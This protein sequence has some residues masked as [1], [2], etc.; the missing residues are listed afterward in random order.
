MR[1]IKASTVLL[2]L[3]LH[4]KLYAQNFEWVK[5]VGGTSSAQGIAMD[6]DQKG[7]IY[8]VGN[9]YGTGDFDPGA[10][11]INLTS[12]GNSDIFIS[13]M[14]PSG[15]ISWIKRIGGL[16]NDIPYTINIDNNDYIYVSGTYE[17]VVDF[18]PGVNVDSL[19][20]VGSSDVFVLKLDDNGNYLWSKSMGGKNV[21][22]SLSL[23]TDDMGNAYITGYFSGTADFN[24]GSGTFNMTAQG[25]YNVFIV[26]ISNNGTFGWAKNIGSSGNEE[27]NSIAIDGDGY[28]YVTGYFT[29]TVDFDPGSSSFFLTSTGGTDIFAVKLDL[30]GDFVWAIKMGGNLNDYGK[31]IAIDASGGVITAGYYAGTADFDPGKGYANLS[32]VGSFDLFISKLSGSGNYT[33][34]KSIGGLDNDQAYGLAVDES[35][36]ISLTGSF[37]GSVDFDPDPVSGFDLV[38]NGI[39]DVFLLQLNASGNF[40]YAGSFGGF[41]LDFGSCVVNDH[42]GRLYSMGYFEGNVDFDPGMGSSFVS[43][44]GG[45]DVFIHKLNFCTPVSSKTS[46]AA[47]GGYTA[48]SG[49]YTWKN[50]GTYYD[51]LETSRGCDSVLV[52]DLSIKKATTSIQNKSAVDSFTWS[53]NGK[54]YKQSGSYTA[55]IKNVAGCDSTITLNLSV[56]YTDVESVEYNVISMFPNPAHAHIILNTGEQYFGT[57]FFIYDVKG[58]LLKQGSIKDKAQ[59][60][61]ISD[62]ERGVYLL[63]INE[64]LDQPLRILKE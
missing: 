25:G 21:D 3:L 41:G 51:T 16:G 12:A 39:E 58:R 44:V 18:D 54:T 13:K 26:K 36:N 5:N 14:L 4:V 47:C 53:V 57:L 2:M 49:K 62:L 32:S 34:A 30:D 11:T 33:W 37:K 43:S 23:I 35:G 19:K 15:E 45:A 50:S 52:I 55:T 63:K 10:N 48:P 8:T 46:A 40:L 7:H 29:G 60:I 27:G 42:K 31:S 6:V 38:S 59:S 24:P 61:D 9:F 1:K 56:Q 17:G 20:S 22:G 28:I 64:V